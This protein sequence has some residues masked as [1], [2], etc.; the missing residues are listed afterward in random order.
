MEALLASTSAEYHKA[1]GAKDTAKAAWDM[2]ASFR[3]GSER[4]KKAKAQQL[5]WEFDNLR[6]KSGE[7]VEDFA[8]RL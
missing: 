3:V 4:A 5:R 1:I 2:L 8:F 7:S 6:F